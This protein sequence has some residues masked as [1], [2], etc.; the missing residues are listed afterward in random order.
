MQCPVC[1]KEVEEHYEVFTVSM[2]PF[3]GV[4][5]LQGLMA[6]G[7]YGVEK[8]T[9]C[10]DGEFV[11]FKFDRTG[12]EHLV[13]MMFY[14]AEMIEAKHRYW[15]ENPQPCEHE[16]CSEIGKP[17]YIHSVDIE[18]NSWLCHEHA[19]EGGFCWS[20]SLFAAGTEEFDFSRSGTCGN[21]QEEIEVDLVEDDDDGDYGHDWF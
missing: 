9:L 2:E 16:G 8:T 4:H 1:K 17:R 5:A 13:K 3:T 11:H 21:C 10:Q 7:G 15:W 6:W 20:C 18:P 14:D 12:Q 19:K